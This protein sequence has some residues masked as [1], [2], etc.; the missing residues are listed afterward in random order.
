M[1]LTNTK[2]VNCTMS[3]PSIQN[4]LILIVLIGILTI[5]VKARSSPASPDPLADSAGKNEPRAMIGGRFNALV[6]DEDDSSDKSEIAS[7]AV[8]QAPLSILPQLQGIRWKKGLL[9]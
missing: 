8:A 7:A 9:L 2:H 4:R 3:F 1:V 5:Q 6:S